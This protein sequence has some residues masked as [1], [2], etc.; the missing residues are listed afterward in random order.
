MKQLIAEGHRA[1]AAGQYPDAAK[2]FGVA[3]AKY[4]KADVT[5]LRCGRWLVAVGEK[6]R[7]KRTEE[8]ARQ[9]RAFHSNLSA[10][11]EQMLSD[12][13]ARRE[14]RFGVESGRLLA[15]LKE[16]FVLIERRFYH[17]CYRGFSCD[18]ICK[19]IQPL[20]ERVEKL[21]AQLLVVAHKAHQPRSAE[22]AE[23]LKLMIQYHRMGSGRPHLGIPIAHQVLDIYRHL[24]AEEDA[25]HPKVDEP[26]ID[27]GNMPTTAEGLQE[28][29]RKLAAYSKAREQ[30]EKR[31]NWEP[32]VHLAQAQVA[33]LLQMSKQHR[34]AAETYESLIGT[35][36]D[37]TSKM[38]LPLYHM[39]AGQARADAGDKDLAVEHLRKAV[40]ISGQPNAITRALGGAQN[41]IDALYIEYYGKALMGVGKLKEARQQ[42]LRAM[43]LR[44]SDPQK[45]HFLTMSYGL[46]ITLAECE[47]Q[48]GNWAEAESIARQYLP[49]PGSDHTT[50]TVQLQ[51][52]FAAVLL[53][54]GAT[55]AK[56]IAAS[57]IDAVRGF[58]GYQLGGL[59]AAHLPKLE[60]AIAKTDDTNLNDKLKAV[61]D[62]IKHQVWSPPA[63]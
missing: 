27:F 19:A 21:Y 10:I 62:H 49:V 22:L 48:L 12:I 7:A 6:L 8:Q 44:Q 30:N 57:A 41:P 54:L 33:E 28:F 3:L 59:A 11:R 35:L 50:T 32:A 4:T 24:M 45:Q 40:E 58:R 60:A 42:L 13:V 14:K 37:P 34:T 23:D 1:F 2:A 26:E 51:V 20:Y 55:D 39:M 46:L 61:H 52:A 9:Y 43:Q 25:L 15:P 29:S 18:D 31:K 53:V 5:W 16:L 17:A 56:D 36:L 47:L 63:Q 38:S